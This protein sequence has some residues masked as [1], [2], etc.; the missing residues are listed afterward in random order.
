MPKPLPVKIEDLPKDQRMV[1]RT[2]I[3]S[4]IKEVN[5]YAEMNKH[6][7]GLEQTEE[8]CEALINKGVLEIVENQEGNIMIIP[9]RELRD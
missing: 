6:G 1:I 3:R 7:V 9:C 8:I 2:L 5:G 4:Y